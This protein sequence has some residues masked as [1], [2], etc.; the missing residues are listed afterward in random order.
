MRSGLGALTTADKRAIFFGL[1]WGFAVAAIYV[2][3][4]GRPK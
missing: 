1:A 4:D 2:W 3:Y